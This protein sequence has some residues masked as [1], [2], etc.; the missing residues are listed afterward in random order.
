MSQRPGQTQT[1][2]APTDDCARQAPTG[3]TRLDAALALVD[4]ALDIVRGTDHR[5]LAGPAAVALLTRFEQVGRAIDGLGHELVNRIAEDADDRIHP[6]LSQRGLLS[7]HLRS[8]EHT[9]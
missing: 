8:E 3:D 2:A 4:Q 1:S 7:R 6:G 9:S 5:M